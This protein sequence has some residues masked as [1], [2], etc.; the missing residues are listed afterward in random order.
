MAGFWLELAVVR[1][2]DEGLKGNDLDVFSVDQMLRQG[3]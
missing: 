2:P 1:E 3:P